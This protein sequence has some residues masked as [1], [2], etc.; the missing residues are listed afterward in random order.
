MNKKFEDILKKKYGN[1]K[2]KPSKE[3]DEIIYSEIKK[4]S[5]LKKIKKLSINFTIAA[6]SIGIIFSI[7]S[8]LFTPK[9]TIIT[10]RTTDK[11]II[12]KKPENKNTSTLKNKEITQ[13]KEQI[14]KLSFNNN[15]TKKQ[16]PEKK[17]PDTLICKNEI[18]IDNN[19]LE[20]FSPQDNILITN[21]KEYVEILIAKPGVYKIYGKNK[22]DIVNDSIVLLALF[23]TPNE[24]TTCKKSIT[25]KAEKPLTYSEKNKTPLSHIT[26]YKTKNGKHKFEIYISAYGHTQKDFIT[27]NFIEKPNINVYI[28]ETQQNKYNIKLSPPHINF[29]YNGKKITQLRN[30]NN[31][32]YTIIAK[33]YDCD[34]VLTIKTENSLS[35]VADFDYIRLYKQAGIPIHFN[36]KTNFKGFKNVNYHWDFGD[37]TISTL[38]NPQHIYI[39]SGNYT[40]RLVAIAD[41]SLMSSVEK[42]IVVLP[43]DKNNQPNVFTPNGDGKNDVFKIQIPIKLYDFKC[44]IYTRNGRKIYE[45]N[46]P[47][48]VWDGKINN[49]NAAEGVYYYIVTGKLEDGKPYIEKNFLYLY[50]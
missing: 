46:D 36:N 3:L 24:I 39:E 11:A 5:F 18:K 12:Q 10:R 29:Y 35:L 17:H 4:F 2:V 30:I 1:K 41:D 45:I 23:I 9:K 44:E 32:T 14:K 47:L 38:E 13:K 20:W 31:G 7:Y 33:Y 16:E 50:R 42:T 40:V 49:N 26:F 8:N 27:I 37:G 21:K 48:Q 25:I 19:N 6:I 28:V 15:I 34:T 43:P 22:N